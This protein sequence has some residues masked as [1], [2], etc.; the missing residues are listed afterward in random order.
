MR[1]LVVLGKLLAKAAIVTEHEAESFAVLDDFFYAK[2][3][4]LNHDYEE[5][6]DN[7]VALHSFANGQLEALA[8]TPAQLRQ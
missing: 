3:K 5:L 4:A 2:L 8:R 6:E 1:A 7:Y